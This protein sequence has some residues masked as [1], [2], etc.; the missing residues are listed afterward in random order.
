M[1]PILVSILG[2][3]LLV[4]VHESGHYLVARAFGI[5]VTRF[6]IGFGPVLAKYQPKGSSTV[7]QIGA[8]PFLAYVMYMNPEDE[9]DPH[10]RGLYTNKGVVARALT[11]LGGPLA[12]YVAASAM[13]FGLAVSGWRVEV[14]RE[15]MVVDAEVGS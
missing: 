15:P 10:D 12:N 7:F 4:I 3:S 1:L 13:I 2:L 5:R 14:P 8:I 11:V 9:A 6:S